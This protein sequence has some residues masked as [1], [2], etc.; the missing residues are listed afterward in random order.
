MITF[1]LIHNTKDH[2]CISN[3][4]KSH[5]IQ[6]HEH[7][8]LELGDELGDPVRLLGLRHQV[9]QTQQL[10]HPDVGGAAA[11]LGLQLL[12]PRLAQHSAESAHIH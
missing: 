4:N 1:H 5:L 11:Q 8:L 7:L 9:Q 6:R 3:S 10:L 2:R 12:H